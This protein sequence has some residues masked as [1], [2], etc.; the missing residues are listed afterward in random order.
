MQTAYLLF[1][2]EYMP[3]DRA[4]TSGQEYTENVAVTLDRE[5]AERFRSKEEGRD[6]EELELVGNYRGQV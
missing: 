6:F 2:K 4:P 1:R 3:V 5:L